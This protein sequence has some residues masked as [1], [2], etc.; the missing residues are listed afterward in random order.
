[1]R[2]RFSGSFAAPC[3]TFSSR[4]A[5]KPNISGTKEATIGRANHSPI[6]QRGRQAHPFFVR[7]KRCESGSCGEKPRSP[8]LDGIGDQT[9]IRRKAKRRGVADRF[10]PEELKSDAI[11]SPEVNRERLAISRCADNSDQASLSVVSG[12]FE[13]GGESREEMRHEVRRWRHHLPPC[14]CVYGCRKVVEHEDM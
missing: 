6:R 7:I 3:E 13:K 12:R 10:I 5:K 11:G 4:V 9:T 2:V 8:R 14:R 1:M